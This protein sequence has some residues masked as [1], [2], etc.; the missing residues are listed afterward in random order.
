[1]KIIYRKGDLLECEEKVVVHGCNAQGV[2]GAGVARA[3]KEKHFR[4]YTQYKREV[5]ANQ[6]YNKTG[7]SL[8]GKVIWAVCG[9]KVIG[10]AI[11]QEFYGRAPIRYCSYDAIRKCMQHINQ[12]IR[13]EGGSVAMPRI[14]AGLAGGDWEII[15][16][17]I[18]E[19]STNFQPVVYE[20]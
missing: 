19:E 16:Q 7:I 15:S 2:M 14:G 9:D 10:N 12:Y 3:I 13:E 1:M 17:I 6:K 18:E 20:L 5:V 11:T 8:L 4:A